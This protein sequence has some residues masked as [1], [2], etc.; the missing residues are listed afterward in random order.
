LISVRGF[1]FP[2]FK[3]IE[4]LGDI[5]ILARLAIKIAAR[6]A[7]QDDVFLQGLRAINRRPWRV[8]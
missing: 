1:L 7:N 6:T 5:R 2:L 8:G 3:G 4:S